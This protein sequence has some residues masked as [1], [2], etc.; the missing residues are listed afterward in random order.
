MHYIIN[1]SY[2][3]FLKTFHSS[4]WHLTAFQSVSTILQCLNYTVNLNKLLLC[5]L[6]SIVPTFVFPHPLCWFE[7]LA[8]LSTKTIAIFLIRPLSTAA[9]SSRF[10]ASPPFCFTMQYPQCSFA[11]SSNNEGLKSAKATNP[12]S[13]LTP[14]PPI[15][16]PTAQ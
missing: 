14:V 7:V 1:G 8:H 16:I 5:P 4:E 9:G 11:P 15:K 2:K 6:N 13:S 12:Q 3:K 10:S